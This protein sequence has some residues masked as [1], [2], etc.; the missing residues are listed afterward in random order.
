MLLSDYLY[1]YKLRI[2]ANKNLR[3]GANY[4]RNIRVG[5]KHSFFRTEIDT[6]PVSYEKVTRLSLDALNEK[7]E[8]FLPTLNCTFRLHDDPEHHF[9]YHVIEVYDKESFMNLFQNNIYPR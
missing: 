6:D 8:Q 3:R 9:W 5:T 1:N 4:P 2:Y 7:E